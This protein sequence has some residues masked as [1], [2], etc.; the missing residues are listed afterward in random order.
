M[1]VD[2]ELDVFKEV[3]FLPKVGGEALVDL[4]E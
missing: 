4:R 1:V 2:Y 3:L